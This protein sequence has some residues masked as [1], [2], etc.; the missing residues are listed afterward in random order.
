MTTLT[1]VR[2]SGA[3]LHT[4]RRVVGYAAI[5]GTLPY[6]TL[7]TCWLLGIDVGVTDPAFMHDSGIFWLNLF[8]A[9]MDVYAVALALVFAHALRAP[10]P[11]VLFPIWVGTGFLAPIA[12]GAPVIA[13][14]SAYAPPAPASSG[15]ELPLAP[16]VQPLVY[17]GFAWQGV[18]L[19]TGFLL[20]A[21][22]RWP[23]IFRARLRAGDAVGAGVVD[24]RGAGGV[25]WTLAG[26][27]GV[28]FAAATAA[29]HLGYA[30]G[31]DLW[32]TAAERA[33]RT[34]VTS[35]VES[36]RGLAALA[37][38]AGVLMLLRDVPA[39]SRSW[40]PVVLG[41][42]GSGSM[43]SWGFWSL[44][45]VTAATV[46]VRDG[47]RPIELAAVLAQFLGGVLLGATV[48]RHCAHLATTPRTPNTAP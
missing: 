9:G 13:V 3:R 34:A 21:L 27:A 42:T 43:F 4:V 37:G 32:F 5:V 46:L 26:Y 11:L 33:S 1:E 44:L 23:T 16:W 7:K 29:V 45:N 19:L 10:A 8:T 30:I 18:F 28:A 12:V 38:A 20:Y 24:A 22:H 25:G 2:P 17:G 40:G 35:G 36:I 14:I 15:A 48:L 41:W 47:V 39:G 6:L 31:L